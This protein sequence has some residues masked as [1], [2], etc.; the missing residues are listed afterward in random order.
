MFVVI[1]K[2]RDQ[3]AF[4]LFPEDI[5]SA[6]GVSSMFARRPHLSCFHHCSLSAHLNQA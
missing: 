6:L 4:N 5:S 3:E 2:F 1:K